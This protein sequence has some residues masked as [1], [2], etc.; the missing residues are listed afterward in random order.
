MNL[1]RKAS[2]ALGKLICVYVLGD[3]T[4]VPEVYVLGD[5]THVPEDMTHVP[6][7]VDFSRIR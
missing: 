7:G 4:H 5:T 6:E 1:D 2:A 3:M